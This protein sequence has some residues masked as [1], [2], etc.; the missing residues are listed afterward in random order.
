MHALAEE[1]RRARDRE[2]ARP[3]ELDSPTEGRRGMAYA[4]EWHMRGGLT[5]IA[6]LCALRGAQGRCRFAHWT[7]AVWR[8]EPRG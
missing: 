3:P 5:E 4:R 1:E 7:T 6:R 8:C 2:V